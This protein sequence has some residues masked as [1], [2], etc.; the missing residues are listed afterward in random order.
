MK[1]NRGNALPMTAA[2]ARRARAGWRAGLLGGAAALSI[3][4]GATSAHAEC[5]TD[6]GDVLVTLC[7][8]A[9]TDSLITL[10]IDDD[11]RS[12][13]VASDATLTSSGAGATALTISAA[14]SGYVSSNLLV[15]GA[16]NGGQGNGLVLDT[17]IGGV[18]VDGGG[19]IDGDVGILLTNASSNWLR[20]GGTISGSSGSAV[21]VDDG[22][23]LQSLVNNAGGTING[24]VAA[25]VYGLYNEGVLISG[26]NQSAA[27]AY[28]A[29]NNGTINGAMVVG[30]N[31]LNNGTMIGGALDAEAPVD[32]AAIVLVPLGE[33]SITNSAGAT[34]SADGTAIYQLAGDSYGVALD[35]AG[36]INGDIDLSQASGADRLVQRAGGVI[37]GNVSLGGGDDVFLVEQG[38]Q[39]GVTGTVD[40]GDG[41]DRYGVLAT[42]SGTITLGVLPAGFEI[43]AIQLADNLPDVTLAA[44]AALADPVELS[45][46]GKVTIAADITTA[47]A[48]ALAA[49]TSTLTGDYADSGLSVVNNAN[50]TATIARDGDD[51]LPAIAAAGTIQRY[52]NSSSPY[53][54]AGVALG[55][56]P[57]ATWGG[58][59]R[60][61]ENNGTI[62]VN[63]DFDIGFAVRTTGYSDNEGNG[64]FV[65]NGTITGNIHSQ[66]TGQ[67]AGYGVLIDEGGAATNT[68]TI[69]FSQGDGRAVFLASSSLINSG[70]ITASDIAVRG[71]GIID[72]SGTIGSSGAAAI[73]QGYGE[74]Y[75]YGS[76]TVVN[77]ADGKIEGAIQNASDGTLNVFNYGDIQGD[78]TSTGYYGTTLYLAAGSHIS[79][80]VSLGDDSL[81]ITDLGQADPLASIDGNLTLNP[82][83][84]NSIRF[85][86]TSDQNAEI[87]QS[88]D[89]F[90]SIGY[91]AAAGTTLTLTSQSP[92]IVPI[93]L[94]GEGTVDL[95][96]SFMVGYGG[97]SIIADSVEQ[98]SNNYYAGGY[99]DDWGLDVVSHGIISANTPEYYVGNYG[100]VTVA[101]DYN[102]GTSFENQGQIN[103]TSDASFTY[104]TIPGRGYL[105]A[106]QTNSAAIINSGTISLSGDN[107]I[108][109]AAID[110]AGI[111]SQSGVVTNSGAITSTGTRK[112]VGVVL[113]NAELVNMADGVISTSGPAVASNYGYIDN[114][115]V[116]ASSG[117]AAIE[118]RLN[119]YNCCGYYAD[120]YSYGGIWVTNRAGGQISGAGKAID[121]F[122]GYYEDF[123][124]NAGAINGDVNLGGGDD[125]FI[126]RFGGALNGS[127]YLG[128]GDDTV[129]VENG[130]TVVTGAIDAGGGVNA[131]GGI[132][133]SSTDVSL[134][135]PQ[136]FQ[137]YALGISGTDTRLV[138]S[139]AGDLDAQLRIYGN[140]GA[141]E[142]NANISTDGLAGI[143]IHGLPQGWDED[144]AMPGLSLVN[145]GTIVVD[146]GAGVEADEGQLISFVN[147]GSITAD[148][149]GVDF[150]SG[151]D[152]G[153]FS[154]T[155]AGDITSFGTGV[156]FN[157]NISNGYAP[158]VLAGGPSSDENHPVGAANV[159]TNSG[160]IIANSGISGEVDGGALVLTNSGSINAVSTG[161]RFSAVTADITNSGSIRTTG[162]YGGALL[163]EAQGTGSATRTVDGKTYSQTVTARVVNSGA[164][165]AE[166]DGYVENTYMEAVAALGISLSGGGGTAQVINQAGGTIESTGQGGIAIAVGGTSGSSGLGLLDSG[167]SYGT[168]NNAFLLVNHGT[169]R[170]GESI[171]IANN[172]TVD[173]ADQSLYL[174]ASLQNEGVGT[175]IQTVGTTDTITNASDG[176][177]VGDIN[178]ADGDDT[179]ENYGRITGK[180][181]LGLGDDTFIQGVSGVLEG[182]VDGGLGSNRLVFELDGDATVD[183]SDSRFTNFQIF[184]QRGGNGSVEGH[185]NADT[186]HLVGTT[187]T[188]AAGKTFSTNGP[189]ALTGSD[190][191]ETVDNSGTIFGDVMLGGGDD[192]F[193]VHPGSSVVGTVDGGTGNDTLEVNDTDT[194]T[195]YGFSPS[196]YLNFETL[197]L[198]GPGTVAISGG[199]SFPFI[200]VIN[201]Y[202]VGLYGSVITGNVLVDPGA[203]FGSAGTVVG[204]IQVGGTLSPGASP[205]TMTVTGNVALASGSNTLFEMTPTI[206]D[207]LLISG[208]LSIAD[209]ATLTLTGERPLTPGESYQL[210]VADGGISGS[211]STIVKPS[212]VQGFIVQDGDSIDLRGEFGTEAGFSQQVVSSI[213]YLNRVLIAGEGVP[214][215]YTSLSNLVTAQG[216]SS[217]AAFA[218]LTPEP[219]ASATEIAVEHALTLI[220]TTRSR[221]QT[222]AAGQQGGYGF[223]QGIGN[224][225]DLDGHSASGAVSA[226]ISTRG[227]LGGLGY[228][229]AQGSD[230]GVFIGYLDSTQQ[231]KAL[232]ARTEADGV[233]G[234]G[235]VNGAFGGFGVH[236]MVAY[237]ASDAR[238][239]RT[240]AAAN[241]KAGS[242]KYDL[243]G[244][245]F[246]LSADYS[247]PISDNWSLTP[248]VGVSHVRAHRDGT[249][250]SGAG[251]FS[252]TVDGQTDRLWFADAG[253]AVTG[254]FTLG[255]GTQ[256]TPYAQ[257]GVRRV[258]D[259]GNITATARFASTSVAP[260]TVVGAGRS[261]TTV[262]MGG[263]VGATLTSG[264]TLFGGYTAEFGNDGNRLG[265]NGGLSLRF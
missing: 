246:D 97:I 148:Y 152:T 223:A 177:I 95:E 173:V 203:I 72:N 160:S 65:N 80:D 117:G 43:S 163:L 146:S 66:A 29:I 114:S 154:L 73:L 244:W 3:M 76:L 103:L 241:G 184:E 230:L 62:T 124:D 125:I 156:Q 262:T 207:Q 39:S 147:N 213:D 99:R 18:V 174:D 27:F 176:V 91:E 92:V 245:S 89:G 48:P 170:G 31:L 219:Y 131:Y 161:I 77:R 94:A 22:F 251:A 260:L 165:A 265:F 226:N 217:P 52:E 144:E 75:Y 248:H 204:N 25:T 1:M 195:R 225:R 24:S 247:A 209:G 49:Y 69:D 47:D 210:I 104:Q 20:N 231:L 229:T 240:V 250:E 234:G 221:L 98:R 183:F 192:R 32:S 122:G 159:V 87:V 40:G 151:N 138:V 175:A 36:T 171:A 214:A 259:D 126:A 16:I 123:V 133:G 57:G 21:V 74:E 120:G 78:I 83:G 249:T 254:A 70:T 201:G 10:G 82:Y 155:N 127:L 81:I 38:A 235:Y 252:L 220:D 6:D 227:V 188:L 162:G 149:D 56:Q 41:M 112:A 242:G 13:I 119:Q 194:S 189:V 140:Q 107:N 130:A 67:A 167:P 191:S 180:V 141:V 17:I 205:A 46:Q 211:F 197:E 190:G 257:V 19:V 139:A 86:A 60:S 215:L 181:Y 33:H 158:T 135:K 26:E 8:G 34:I 179:I 212:S 96:A 168:G 100:V 23:T 2:K 121:T 118:G 54:V 111:W 59:L 79:G 206:S 4:A 264:L 186:Y 61:F 238:T 113:Q 237:D 228:R 50:I 202:L 115:G 12:I 198:T 7:S 142:N 256:M 102:S 218:Q 164:I 44:D 137:A 71:N 157:V 255:S 143:R 30:A 153:G 253:M 134:T 35:N 200:H 236:A 63:G 108:G 28:Q 136:D 68:G 261:R 55:Y 116:L 178:L 9:A 169:V 232:G 45:G 145:N 109:D 93:T 199:A 208:T 193:I 216:G 105:N 129:L 42:Q 90:S 58:Y 224:W 110:L 258:L 14:D 106:I 166:G 53:Y 196:N 37:N 185:V 182:N 51:N 172:M 15:R 5:V 187:F 84:N 11:G 88:V 233:V 128:D 85:R 132:Y 150:Y 239:T 243:G 222:A 64:V 101:G 263:G